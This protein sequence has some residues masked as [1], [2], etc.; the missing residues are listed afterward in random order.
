MKTMVVIFGHGSR[1]PEH[2]LGLQQVAEMVK[3]MTKFPIECAY[4]ENCEPNIATVI[5]SAAEQGFQ[6]FIVMPFFLFKGIHVTED[7]PKEIAAIKAELPTIE[8]IFSKH[9]GVDPKLAEI[10]MERIQE[11]I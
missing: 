2:N 1:A 9:L 8:V 7:V 11:V 5:R 6:K 10:V 4:M 3:T